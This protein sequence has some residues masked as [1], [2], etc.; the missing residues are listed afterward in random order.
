M[1]NLFDK[2]KDA[3]DLMGRQLVYCNKLV[4]MIWIDLSKE[5]ETNSY[6]SKNLVLLVNKS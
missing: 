6:K 3:K 2:F 4:D 5:P 1:E